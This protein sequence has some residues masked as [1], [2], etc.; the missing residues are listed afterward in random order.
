MPQTEQWQVRQSRLCQKEKEQT[1]LSRSSDHE[2]GESQGE[3][4][5][6]L[7]E[8]EGSEREHGK[9]SIESTVNEGRFQGGEGG[10]ARRASLGEVKGSMSG[11]VD[12]KILQKNLQSLHFTPSLAKPEMETEVGR[13]RAA[14]KMTERNE[15]ELLVGEVEMPQ[16]GD[17]G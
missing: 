12:A 10:Q 1:G 5:S 6:Q 8:R 2:V 16:R 11:L 7:M 17:E 14:Y 9:E 13:Q 3:Q 4:K 15:S